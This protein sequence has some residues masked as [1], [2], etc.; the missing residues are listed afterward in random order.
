VLATIVLLVAVAAVVLV[1]TNP[2][3]GS[4]SGGVRDNA[5]ATSLARV[6]R[7]SLTSLIEV[8]GTLGY[9]GDV[10]VGLSAGSAPAMVTQAQQAVTTDKGMLASARSTLSSDS[11][12]QSQ[13]SATLA[14]D[15]QQ[16]GVE[17]A[18][19]NAAQGAAAGGAGSGAGS[20]ACATDAQLVAGGQ[21]SVTADAARVAADEVSVS[22]AKR[23][24]AAD[25][26]ELA[27]ASAQATVYGESSAFTSVPS[28]GEIVRR[29][30]SLFAIDSEPTVLLYGSRSA[31]RSFTAGM[32]PGTDVAELNANLDAL[33]YG[34]G[35]TGSAF[36]P[37]TAAA[38][39]RLQAAHGENAT[40][41][42]LVGSVVFEPGP[43]RVTSLEMTVAVGAAVTAGPVLSATGIA[44][45]IQ[46][47]LDPALQGQVRAGDPVTITL[48]ND[49]TLPGRITQ[50]SSVATPGQNG[51]P[52]TIAVDAVP[53]DPAA[54]GRL[55]Q[56]PVNVSITTGRVSNALVVPVDALLALESGGYA[57]EEVAT[58]GVHHLVAVSTGLFDDADGL[59]Q[60]RGPGLAGGQ[61]VVVPGV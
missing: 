28:A 33:G 34:H 29:G 40:G 38:I 11:A 55:D 19:D 12:A 48:P 39:R 25:G 61:R 60:V 51:S 32:L 17:C 22:S 3:G 7:Q 54:I 27:S 30:Q 56:A 37:A 52:P 45:Q 9:T 10:T 21:Q 41:Q 49:Q 6:R 35:L 23:S 44:R 4:S 59:V 42:L 20:G 50:V 15:Q 47:Q 31:T 1:V 24:L 2:F 53:T 14:A 16:E 57:I 26:A 8:G 58:T 5:S 36:T 46:I 43:I 18:G 13:A